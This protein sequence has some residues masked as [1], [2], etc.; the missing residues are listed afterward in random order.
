MSSLSF[1]RPRPNP[2]PC[3]VIA[4]LGQGYPLYAC[5]PTRGCNLLNP[6]RERVQIR[7]CFNNPRPTPYPQPFPGSGVEQ[8]GSIIL[9]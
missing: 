1:S 8:N 9:N 6:G 7:G 3:P 4:T 2:E 5:T